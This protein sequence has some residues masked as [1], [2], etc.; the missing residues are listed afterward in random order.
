MLGRS[1]LLFALALT[2]CD[3]SGVPPPGQ[4]PLRASSPQVEMD[5]VELRRDG[6][7]AGP[8]AFYFAAGQNEVETALTSTLGEVL[9][10]SDNQECG[11]GPLE[12]VRFQG[13]LAVHFQRGSLVG[14]NISLPDEAS[15]A[16]A[17]RVQVVGDVQVGTSKADAIEADGF[18]LLP[19]STLGE[20][21]T[22]GDAMGGFMQ[23]AR[24][25]MLY[26]GAQCFF[27]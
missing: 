25:T 27:R 14:W 10:R 7:V 19:D 3:S 23:D 22:L 20:E 5:A 2:A 18:R 15:E 9:E 13:G 11:G 24:V 21:F 6:L 4:E 16:V 26:A 12:F 1:A 17:Q 8:E